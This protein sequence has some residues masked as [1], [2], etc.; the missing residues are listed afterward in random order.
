[1]GGRWLAFMGLGLL[2]FGSATCTDDPMDPCDPPTSGAVVCLLAGEDRP[3]G[4]LLT[5]DDERAGVLGS[6][7]WTIDPGVGQCGDIGEIPELGPS[8]RVGRGSTVVIVEDADEVNA[9]I[10][11]L[12]VGDGGR[13]LRYVADLDFTEGSAPLRVAPG[14]YVL[15]VSGRWDQGDGTLYFPID[16]A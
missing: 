15:E 9:E 6:Y 16:V 3:T 13:Q 11:V 10:A 4:R 2:L 12:D 5:N 7:C 1:M 8:V 14:T